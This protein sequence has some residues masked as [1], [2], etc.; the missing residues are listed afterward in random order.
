VGQ[1]AVLALSHLW[2]KVYLILKICRRYFVVKTFFPFINSLFRPKI[3]ALMLQ[4]RRKIIQN[5]QFLNPVYY[6]EGNSNF[7]QISNLSHIRKC[8]KVWL[9]SGRSPRTKFEKAVDA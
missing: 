5:R 2:A 4:R 6:G 8:E 7:S 1:N 3:S 9:S